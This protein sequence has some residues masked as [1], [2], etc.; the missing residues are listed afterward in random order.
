MVESL[1]GGQA[2]LWIG[3]AGLFAWVGGVDRGQAS[4]M[5]ERAEGLQ[6]FGGQ[7]PRGV[8]EAK[9]AHSVLRG[10]KGGIHRQDSVV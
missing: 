5:G 6:H 10:Q 1:D 8:D 9:G 4:R 2:R 3:A 7:M